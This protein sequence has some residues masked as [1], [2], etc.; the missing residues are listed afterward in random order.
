M[1][2]GAQSVRECLAKWQKLKSKF[3]SSHLCVPEHWKHCK[4]TQWHQ[5]NIKASSLCRSAVD[6]VFVITVDNMLW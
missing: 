5:W 2:V 3:G 6:H 1:L 4:Y